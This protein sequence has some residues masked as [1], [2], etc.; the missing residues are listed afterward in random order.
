M[1]ID[2]HN[3]EEYFILYL[4]E[5][6]SA[7]ERRQVEQF[8]EQHP[9]LKE[10]FD[11]LL[12]S[13]LPVDDAVVFA[14]KQSLLRTET[15]STINPANF[16]EYCLLYTDNELTAAERKQVEELA[17]GSPELLAELQRFARTV[18]NPETILFP[19]KA[20]LYRRE[21]KKRPVVYFTIRRIA[22][23]AGLILA[24][25]TTALLLS[26]S[27]N[28]RTTDESVAVNTPSAETSNGTEVVIPSNEPAE[29]Q[30]LVTAP[31]GVEVV[32]SENKRS[33]I[34]PS[35]RN[36]VA[37]DFV[38][39]SNP[40]NLAQP[41]HNP[42]V[43]GSEQA[44][45]ARLDKVE[46]PATGSL[47]TPKQINQ[48]PTVTVDNAR[49]LQSG[50]M[51]ASNSV[52]PEADTYTEASEPGRKNKLR[53]FFRKVTRTFEKTTNIQATDDEDRL[54]VGSLSIRL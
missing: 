28:E 21:E 19:D 39:V 46:T 3:Y 7:G 30:T 18:A 16:E 54:L 23:A 5:E 33:R 6:L 8:V 52:E 4:D 34:A 13:K 20:S 40:N 38:N 29:P 37:T 10:E 36:E 26:R 35:V 42:N 9:D 44:D 31:A 32:A 2:R 45:V 11:L 12:S 22:I 48:L 17:A 41:T 15:G 25:S 1:N 49:P 14:D 47:T 50:Y 24:V 51:T 43:N 53:G 27:N